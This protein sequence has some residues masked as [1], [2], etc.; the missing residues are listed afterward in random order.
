MCGWVPLIWKI[1]KTKWEEKRTDYRIFTKIHVLVSPE[2]EL[3]S[4]SEEESE[5]DTKDEVLIAYHT[6]HHILFVLL[7]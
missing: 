6:F 1:K 4:S 2:N 3:G 5:S 7:L